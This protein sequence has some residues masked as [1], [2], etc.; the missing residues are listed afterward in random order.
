MDNRVTYF[1]GFITDLEKKDFIEPWSNYASA[2]P[3][4]HDQVKLQERTDEKGKFRY[5]SR[6]QLAGRDFNFSFM[7]GRTSENFSEYKAR[8]MM[9]GGYSVSSRGIK[10]K[11]ANAETRVVVLTNKDIYDLDPFTEIVP[12]LSLTIYEP[13]FENCKYSSIMEF[14]AKEADAKKLIEYLRAEK[15]GEEIAVYRNCKT[16][17]FKAQLS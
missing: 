14:S 9:L 3:V 1:V 5:I 11:H 16:P 7:K 15:T 4:K 17:A 2:F 13:F 6:H 10:G 12:D 8:V